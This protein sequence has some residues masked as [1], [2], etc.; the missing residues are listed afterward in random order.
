M[1]LLKACSFL[2]SQQQRVEQVPEQENLEHR[3]EQVHG[4]SEQGS[5]AGSGAG[6]EAGSGAGSQV[7]EEV[8]E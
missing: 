7:P 4:A 5:A 6:F 3:L 2:F 1:G 8:P